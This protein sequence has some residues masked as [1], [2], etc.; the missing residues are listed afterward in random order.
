MSGSVSKS[1]P[2]QG[3]QDLPVHSEHG[4]TVEAGSSSSSSSD[5]SVARASGTADGLLSTFTQALLKSNESGNN[6]TLDEAGRIAQ[7]IYDD[8]NT[9]Q[10]Y[11][12]SWVRS[13]VLQDREA[14]QAL[15]ELIL[16]N[17]PD[18]P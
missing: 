3:S 1:G 8:Y 13:E 10:P 18:R 9:K 15:L 12:L 5:V 16:Q 2:I 17:N 6:L 11:F 4:R 14:I 7:A